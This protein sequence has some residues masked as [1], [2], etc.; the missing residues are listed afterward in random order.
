MLAYSVGTVPLPPYA[1]SLRQ[2][3]RGDVPSLFEVEPSTDYI[4]HS[5]VSPKPRIY[6]RELH[7]ASDDRLVNIWE[8]VIEG[9]LANLQWIQ[10]LHRLDGCDEIGELGD[11]GQTLSTS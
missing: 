8:I 4:P 2:L 10:V 1:T 6:N 5:C 3:L 7:G 9:R 11:R